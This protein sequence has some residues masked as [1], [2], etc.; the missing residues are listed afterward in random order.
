[1]SVTLAPGDLMPSSGFCGYLHTCGIHS[2]K[3]I[4]EQLKINQQENHSGVQGYVAL[5]VFE[6]RRYHCVK[7][8]LLRCP[9]DYIR[10]DAGFTSLPL[11]IPVPWQHSLEVMNAEG[12]VVWY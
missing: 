10:E 5:R 2:L 12:A 3:H 11:R 1:M 6:Q 9:I 8:S 7:W 4:E